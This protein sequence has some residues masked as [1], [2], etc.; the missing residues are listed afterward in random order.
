MWEAEGLSGGFVSHV[1][2]LFAEKGPAVTNAANE[3]SGFRVWAQ[4]MRSISD[5]PS[6]MRKTSTY[7][8]VLRGH[9]LRNEG[10]IKTFFRQQKSCENLRLADLYHG[11]VQERGMSPDENSNLHKGMRGCRTATMW[12]D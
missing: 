6:Q 8:S 4:L 2:K 9:V 5:A 12:G 10:E 11:N 7:N 3:G 1:D